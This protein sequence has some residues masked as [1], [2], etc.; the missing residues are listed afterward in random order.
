[1]YFT[2]LDVLKRKKN[3]SNSC[4]NLLFLTLQEFVIITFTNKYSEL[5]PLF[6]F[7][8]FHTSIQSNRQSK[9]EVRKSVQSG[10]SGWKQVQGVI[11]DRKTA[12]RVKGNFHRFLVRFCI[13]LMLPLKKRQET[14]LE[15]AEQSCSDTAS[16]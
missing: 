15:V 10:Q 9:K 14:E 11:W 1:M 8:N 16:F 6:Q 3:A 5:A 4:E 12:A 2:Y 13:V 7:Q